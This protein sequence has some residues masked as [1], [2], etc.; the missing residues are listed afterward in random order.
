[1]SASQANPFTI[2][3]YEFILANPF[4]IRTCISL[5]K[6]ATYNLFTIRTYG[7]HFH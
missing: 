5:S 2:R 7:H 4:R 6:Q 1:M 3:T